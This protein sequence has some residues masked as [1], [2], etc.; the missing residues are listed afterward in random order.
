MGGAGSG[1]FSSQVDFNAQGLCLNESKMGEKK[2]SLMYQGP[3][4]P[5]NTIYNKTILTLESSSDGHECTCPD[6]KRAD[7]KPDVNQ[8]DQ[9]TDGR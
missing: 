6:P 2:D 8:S 1:F 7:D 9:K 3:I 4:M 5:F